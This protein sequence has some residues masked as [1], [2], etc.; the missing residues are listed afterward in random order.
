MI[1]SFNISFFNKIMKELSNELKE[2]LKNINICCIKISE[3]KNLNCKFKKIEFLEKEG[4]YKE[5]QN[6]KFIE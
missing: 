6:T 1:N 3:Q 4:F 5:Y 2:V